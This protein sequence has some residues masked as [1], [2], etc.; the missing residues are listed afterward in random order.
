MKEPD[1]IV[2]VIDDE[3]L[4]RRGLESLLKSSGLRVET[5]AS[6]HEFMETKRLDA[7]GCLVLDVGL[8]GLSG[9]DLQ[10]QLAEMNVRIPIIFITG[11][12][13]IPITVRAMREGAFDFLTKPIRGPDLLGAIHRAIA[14]DHELRNE[15][16][17]SANTRAGFASNSADAKS[18]EAPGPL[19]GFGLDF[20]PLADTAAY[21]RLS[22]A[23]LNEVAPFGERCS[24]AKNKPLVG[25]GDYP[26]NSHVILSGSVRVV[27]V[28][29]GERVVFVR[30]GAGYFTGDIDLFTRRPSLVS[31]EAETIV[32]AIRL[33]PSQLR[34]FFTQ[35]PRLGEKFWKSFQ[36]RRELLLVSKFRGLSI[37]GK[38]GDKRTLDTIEL[39]FRNSVPHEWFDTSIEENSRKLEQIREDVQAYPVITHG[40]RVLF[41]APTRAQLADHLHLR[42]SLPDSV[43]D[44]LILG[45]GPAGLGA[46]VYAASEGLSS[47]VLDALGPGGQAGS[48][49]RIENYAGFPDGVT[50]WDLAFLT[51]LQAL[52]FG[53]DFHIPS[54]VSNLERR[55]NGLYRVRTLEADYV[56]G[57]TV[58][59]ATGVSYGEPM[60][61]GLAAL[62]GKG[63]YYSAT[64]IES[65]LCRTSAAHVVG[66][67]N[68]AG[69][70]A[71]F[72]SETADE[73][74]LLVR[75]PDLRKMSSYLAERVIANPKIRVRYNTEVVGI[76]GVEHICG[77]HV[78]EPNGETHEEFTS[79]LFVFIGAKP[80]TDFLP[81]PI[82]RNAQGFVLTGQEVAPLPEWKEP[83]PPC[84]VETSLPGVFAA[85]DCRN[86]SPKRVAFAIGDGA[87][88]VTSVHNFLGNTAS[89]RTRGEMIP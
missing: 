80:R 30:Y 61:E 79:G 87:T 63:V 17:E 77:L 29:T 34:E 45:A 74:S 6:A 81:A 76:E 43:Y 12:G 7:P 52:K 23:E 10:R 50:G 24:F 4:V 40:S 28:S 25:A 89:E 11:R 38:K 35:K 85:G 47:L 55:R 2:Y 82:I 33:T 39:L 64:N 72:L 56:L 49:S 51:Y 26:F 13:D 31:V 32:E 75:G 48:T 16:V 9:L 19:R 83:R 20:D 88:A 18:P 37:Y 73:V 36:R 69:Q 5:F 84:V 62:Q 58:I 60:V 1:A 71:M 44:I 14:R 66:A 53:A 65:R 22:A 54:T 70:A 46:S 68:S 3:E 41:E 15:R 59:I 86:G 42:R 27:D 78:R 21:P 67:G 57:R 8:P